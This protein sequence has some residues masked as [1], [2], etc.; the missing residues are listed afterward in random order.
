MAVVA[1]EFCTGERA[2]PSSFVRSFGGFDSAV[3]GY[4]ANVIGNASFST[5]SCL[6]VLVILEKLMVSMEGGRGGGGLR[7][8]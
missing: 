3:T 4:T 5:L 6:A 1:K 8:Y 7:L 2:K